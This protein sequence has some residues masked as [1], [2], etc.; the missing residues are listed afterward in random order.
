MLSLK[1]RIH[2][3][4][5]KRPSLKTNASTERAYQTM[6]YLDAEP[7][8]SKPKWPCLGKTEVSKKKKRFSRL[9]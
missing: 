1:C 2:H 8:E 3:A 6:R 4:W 5:I 7:D 9:W